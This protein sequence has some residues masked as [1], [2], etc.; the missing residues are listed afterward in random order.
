MRVR[1]MF[2]WLLC[3]WAFGKPMQSKILSRRILLI[4]VFVGFTIVSLVY[5]IHKVSTPVS[6]VPATTNTTV[7]YGPKKVYY[8]LPV[9]L[10]IPSIN[11]DTTL[12]YVG[13]IPGGAM[14]TPKKPENAAWF[15]LGK[16]PGEIGS[17]VIA[18]HYGT[19]KNG[20]G[21]VFDELHK[22]NVGNILSV[23]DDKGTVISFVVREKRNYDPNANASDV[24]SSNDGKS[25][26][27]LITCEGKWD[28]SS[29]SYS[30]RLVVFTDKE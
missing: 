3:L 24:F 16:R 8:G 12:E 5:F 28:D 2:V 22:L 4:V 19:W 25:H 20:Q 7:F 18:G 11:V 13:R 1:R 30:K 29:K 15:E 10:K 26:L 21:S 9:R 23:E 27:N 17:A 14:D 6:S